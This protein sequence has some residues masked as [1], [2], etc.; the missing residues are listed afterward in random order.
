MKEPAR[1]SQP[2]HRVS[3][4]TIA[5]VVSFLRRNSILCVALFVGFP[6]LQMSGVAVASWAFVYFDRLYG[7]PLEQAAIAFSFSAGITTIIGC[8]L[9]GRLVMLLRRRGYIDASLR[10][11]LLGGILFAAFAVLGLLAPGPTS[12]LILFSM[13][14]SSRICRLSAA[15]ARSVR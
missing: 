13:A 1:Q 12:A 5:E 9:S 15:S 3:E 6:L 7:M 8:L 11:C 10:A 4:D 14:F 2:V